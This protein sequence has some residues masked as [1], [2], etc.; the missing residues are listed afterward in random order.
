MS[1]KGPKSSQSDS[2]STSSQ[3]NI[4]NHATQKASNLSSTLLWKYLTIDDLNRLELMSPIEIE[5]YLADLFGFISYEI[6]LKQACFLDYYVTQYWWVAKQKKLSNEQI[7]TYFSIVCILMENL[8]EKTYTFSQNINQLQ[9]ILSDLNESLKTFSDDITKEILNYI[10]TT[11]FQNYK[12]YEYVINESQNEIIIPKEMLVECPKE[13]EFPYPPPLDEAMSEK[14]YRK[15]VLKIDDDVKLDDSDKAENIDLKP[16]VIEQ[17]HA[18]FEGLSIDEAKQV[19]FEVTNDLI[20]DLKIDM[21]NKIKAR[22]TALINELAK[23]QKK[24]K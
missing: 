4:G 2:G 9:T 24:N 6:D 18:K 22:E 23:S 19:I 16:E 8:K 7:S 14:I 17:I 5:K 10:S 13:D 15:Y 11:F 3:Q 21:K 1:K 20:A 12:L